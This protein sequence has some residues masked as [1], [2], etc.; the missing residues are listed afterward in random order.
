MTN[1]PKTYGEIKKGLFKEAL[2][3]AIKQLKPKTPEELESIVQIVL[4]KIEN[5]K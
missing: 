2:Q 1:K 3:K 5:K 4:H